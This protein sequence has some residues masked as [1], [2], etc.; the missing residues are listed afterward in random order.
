MKGFFC[1]LGGGFFHSLPFH[2]IKKKEMQYLKSDKLYIQRA[3]KVFPI[4][5]RQAQI[6]QKI[7]YS[8]LAKEVGIPNPRNL[9]YVLGAIG[10]SINTIADDWEEEIPPIQ[11]I[12]INKNRGLPGEGFVGFLSNVDEYQKA[13]KSK[14]EEIINMVLSEIFIYPHWEEVLEELDLKPVEWIE[15]KTKKIVRKLRKKKYQGSDGEGAEHKAF[16]ERIFNN[17]ELVKIKLKIIERY[18]EYE[19]LSKD[20]IDVLFKGKFNWIGIEVKSKK[21]SPEDVLRGI[22]QVIKYQSLLKAEQIIEGIEPEYRCVLALEGEIPKELIP[23]ANQ[24]KVE[25]IEVR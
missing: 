13:S 6:G 9:N 2:S 4:L 10:E 20:K 14:R 25:V 19:F 18:T 23:I 21:S 17:P 24:L 15:P 8:D 12:V 7:Y 22:F 16:K 3:R 5:V 11:C 1:E